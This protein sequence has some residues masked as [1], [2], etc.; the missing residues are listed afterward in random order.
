MKKILIIGAGFL[1]TFVIKKAKELGY[2]VLTV[3]ANPNAEGFCY[4]D[5]YKNISITDE[6]ACLEYALEKQIDG[7]MTAATDYGVLTAAYIAEKMNLPG[8]SYNTACIIKNKYEVKR[9]LFEHNIDDTEQVFQISSQ[10]N[11]KE[12]NLKIKYPVMVKP[13]DGSGSRGTS[14]VSNSKEL[15]KACFYAIENSIIKKAEIETFIEGKEYGVESFVKNKN[16]NVLAIMEKEMTPPPNYAELGHSMPSG[17]TEE[18]EIKI[19]QYVI[20]AIEVLKINFG[21]VNMDII[22]S[23][24][25][26]IYIVDV[27]ARMGGNLIGSHIVPLATGI[28]YLSNLIRAMV[29]D[30]FNLNP[31]RKAQAVST[32]LLAL[33]PGTISQLPDFNQMEKENDVKIFHHLEIG[34]KIRKYQ[35]NLDGC[36][37]VVACSESKEE[38]AQKA[39]HVRRL[40]DQTIIRG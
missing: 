18:Q 11:L 6:K 14:K 33:K 39:D 5:E 25:N 2:Y 12:I 22:V 16:I 24:E 9:K 7:V 3:D 1:Q 19:K 20:Q 40:I 30:S 29:N 38:T 26:E 17:L 13:C 15:Q 28:D 4:A 27:G 23:K 34:Q 31:S 35:T 8:L 32:R 21:A 37:Y 10:T 36:G